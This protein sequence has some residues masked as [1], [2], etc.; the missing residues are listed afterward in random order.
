[1]APTVTQMDGWGWMKPDDQDGIMITLVSSLSTGIG[2]DS[3]VFYT[4]PLRR[5]S[6]WHYHP[7]ASPELVH[8]EGEVEA[9]GF[10]SELGAGGAAGVDDALDAVVDEPGGAAEEEDVAGA[11]DDG[12]G[13]PGAG[14]VLGAGLGE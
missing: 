8:A 4:D 9:A 5:L 12:V 7:S 3:R 14:L 10:E 1:M 6:G 13:F 2:A 11:E